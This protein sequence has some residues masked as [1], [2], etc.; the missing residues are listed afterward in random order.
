MTRYVGSTMLQWGLMCATFLCLDFITAGL[1]VGMQPPHEAKK[2]LVG[3]L[4]ALLSIRSRVFNPMNNRRQTWS[5]LEEERRK[6][7]RPEWTPPPSVFAFVWTFIAFLRGA[8]SAII[9]ETCNQSLFSLPLCVYALHLSIG[10][11]WNAINN[12]ERR[13]GVA[14]SS[15]IFV[16]A[17]AY[18]VTGCYYTYNPLAGYL[19][20]PLS[21]WLSIAF[22]ALLLLSLSLFLPLVFNGKRIPSLLGSRSA[23]CVDVEVEWETAFGSS[24]GREAALKEASLFS[25]SPFWWFPRLQSPKPGVDMS[26]SFS[27]RLLYICCVKVEKRR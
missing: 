27:T 25:C 23:C 24:Q 9:W 20:V 3:A 12:A 6:R 10:D 16:L 21:V 19:L 26:L 17:S 7:I 15:M 13:L 2:P 4:C 22:G 1:P 18:G 8:S 5:E 11:G 14:A